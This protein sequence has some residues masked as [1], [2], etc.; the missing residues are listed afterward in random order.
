[1]KSYREWAQLDEQQP[2][3]QQRAY[4]QAPQQVA[5]QQQMTSV[6]RTPSA[7]Q[8]AAIEKSRQRQGQA[9]GKF[10][11]GVSNAL[12]AL[13]VVSPQI[14]RR[15]AGLINQHAP[16]EVKLSNVH[17][18]IERLA[19]AAEAEAAKKAKEQQ[20][21]TQPQTAYG[22]TIQQSAAAQQMQQQGVPQARGGQQTYMYPQQVQ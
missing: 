17:T 13:S 16:E 9:V 11:Y 4:Q 3:M 7:A 6:S 14:L 5:P 1:M 20:Q 22:T 2:V 19:D 8:R 21:Q 18:A 10:E 12:R 15:V